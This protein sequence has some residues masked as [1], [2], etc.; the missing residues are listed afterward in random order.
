[1]Y[2]LHMENVPYLCLT[3]LTNM[4]DKGSAS[5]IIIHITIIMGILYCPTQ[6]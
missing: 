5:I 3:C 2:F 1:M 4:A 6:Q